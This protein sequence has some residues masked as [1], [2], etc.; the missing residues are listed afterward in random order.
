MFKNQ[1]RPPDFCDSTAYRKVPK[2]LTEP[3]FTYLDDQA[4]NWSPYEDERRFP[5]CKMSQLFGP[6][7][8]Y[9]LWG[10]R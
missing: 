3:K 1:P 5:H 7:V 10:E 8:D 2:I 9:P 6:N 4:K